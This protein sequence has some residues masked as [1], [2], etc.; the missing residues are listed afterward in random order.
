MSVGDSDG[1]YLSRGISETE[2]TDKAMGLDT[3]NGGPRSATQDGR[4]RNQQ[5]LAANASTLT[6]E[7]EGADESE[8]SRLSLLGPMFIPPQYTGA[9][10]ERGARN[11]VAAL[12]ISAL[13]R[14]IQTFV[15]VIRMVGMVM[16]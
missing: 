14:G 3:N 4:T 6:P 7:H 1:E 8:C 16:T 5:L 9:L 10:R 2:G 11:S 13:A 12:L 15:T